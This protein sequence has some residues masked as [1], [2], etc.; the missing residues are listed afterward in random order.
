MKKIF[1]DHIEFSKELPRL[2]PGYQF[3][4]DTALI[5]TLITVAFF[6]LLVTVIYSSNFD[7]SKIQVFVYLFVCSVGVTILSYTL[8]EKNRD[9]KG[10]KAYQDFIERGKIYPITRLGKARVSRSKKYVYLVQSFDDVELSIKL[11][12]YLERRGD[13]VKTIVGYNRKN[14]AKIIDTVEVKEIFPDAPVN[15]IFILSE[16]T[17]RLHDFKRV[18]EYAAFLYENGEK[19]WQANFIEAEGLIA[20]ELSK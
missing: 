3:L 2:V 15:G 18:R 11:V 13:F 4:Y 14:H 19:K 12:D 16:A 17:N 1:K 6:I 5:F 9:T 8:K 7:F 20:D 10:R